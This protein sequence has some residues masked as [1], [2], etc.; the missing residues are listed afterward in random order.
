[1]RFKLLLL[2]GIAA[3]F[4]LSALVYDRYPSDLSLTLSLQAFEHPVLTAFM[5]MVSFIGKGWPMVVLGAIT[6]LCFFILRRRRECY[7]AMGALAI[8][9]LNPIFKKRSS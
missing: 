9:G 3:S 5:E 6:V 2:A 7:A 1:M 8:M 4:S